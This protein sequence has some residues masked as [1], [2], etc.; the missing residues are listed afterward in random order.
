MSGILL[1]PTSLP[2]PF[3]IGDM[4][5]TAYQFVDFLVAGGQ[6]LWQILPLGPTGFGNSPYA[7]Y[8]AI[9]GNPLLISPE[10]LAQAGWLDPQDWQ[11]TAEWPQLQAQFPGLVDYPATIRLK[12]HLMRTAFARFKADASDT[13]HKDFQVFCQ[14]E[15]DW[16][17]DYALFAVLHAA[18]EGCE[19]CDWPDIEGASI[20]RREPEAIAAA[21]QMYA[22]EIEY[23]QFV[24]FVFLQQWLDLKAYAGKHDVKIFGDVPIYVAYN[25]ADV[26]ANRERFY[27]DEDCK[28]EQ[29]AGVPPDYFSDTGQLW[30]NPIYRWD[31]LKERGYDWWI[32]RFQHL[33]RFVDVVRIDHFR[34]FEAYWSVPGGAETAIEGK[35][36]EGP[37]A[38]F[39]EVLRDR[40]GQLPIVAEDL[41]VITPEVEALRDQF[42]FPGMRILQFAFDGNPNNPYLPFNYVRN[43][44]VYTGTHDNDTMVGWFYGEHMRPDRGY[45]IAPHERQNVLR[46]LGYRSLDDIRHDG[47]H[48][49]FIR[50]AMSSVADIAVIPLQDVLGLDRDSRMNFPATVTE[51]WQWRFTSD[52]LSSEVV[53]KLADLCSIYNRISSEQ[54]HQRL[55]RLR[56]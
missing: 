13:R 7:C 46:Y 54:H 48:W 41:G 40:L 24:E 6:K 1:H 42:Q 37:G 34:A 8:S 29:V 31:V 50:M 53:E 18:H 52:L 44:A 5:P 55:H 10:L 43:C 22:D 16:L 4:G 3:G 9:A 30:G 20:A 15:A 35:W 32:F 38:H 26:W 45:G 36:V 19:W 47:I 11:T 12:R 25:S 39:F 33:L 49:D 2:S 27:L 14:A 56:H 17:D 28:P 23:R 21:R 51:N